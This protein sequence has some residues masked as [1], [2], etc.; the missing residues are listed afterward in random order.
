MSIKPR[1]RN[2]DKRK[3]CTC[4]WCGKSFETYISRP[5]RFC[6]RLCS[7][8]YGGSVSPGHPKKPESYVTLCCETCG[9]DYVVHRVF[10]E[11]RNSRFCSHECQYKGMSMERQGAGN[12]AYT[13]GRKFPN[14]GSNWYAQRKAALMRDG[15][16]CRI[17]GR[18]AKKGE[19]RVVDVHHI[20]PYRLFEGDYIASNNLLNLITLCRQCHIKVEDYEYPCPQPLL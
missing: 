1:T 12:P 15:K 18:K 9:K 10:I 7:A 11:K 5:G 17:C 19:R 6:S 16:T 14:R 13:G 2:P 3:Q 8:H 20:K 4:E